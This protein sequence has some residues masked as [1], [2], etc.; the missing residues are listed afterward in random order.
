MKTQTAY[1]V[2]PVLNRGSFSTLPQ[3]LI[4]CSSG[5]R[6]K[7]L[8]FAPTSDLINAAPCSATELEEQLDEN[9][10]LLELRG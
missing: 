6:C 1:G 9:A 4:Q 8:V 5:R 10:N 7:F 3:E 2:A